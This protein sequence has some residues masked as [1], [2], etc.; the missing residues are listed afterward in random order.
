MT[1]TSE[2]ATGG[3]AT[4][5]AAFTALAAVAPISWGTTY[6]VTT[7][8]LPPDHRQ[9]HTSTRVAHMSFQGALAGFV[10]SDRVRCAAALGSS[11]RCRPSGGSR[12]TWVGLP[13][14]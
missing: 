5:T 12:Q 13:R 7:E 4:H 10:R 14:P 3:G 9:V 1:Q 8:F 11:R 6:L 2:M